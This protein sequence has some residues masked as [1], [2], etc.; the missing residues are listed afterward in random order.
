M[1][2]SAERFDLAIE[3]RKTAQ[4]QIVGFQEKIQRAETYLEKLTE[5][6]ETVAA[7]AENIPAL[8][9]KR[10]KL[11]GRALFSC[12]TIGMVS[13]RQ[14]GAVHGIEGAVD[15]K[16]RHSVQPALTSGIASETGE[17]G[18]DS[19][20]SPS[21]GTTGEKG[22]AGTAKASIIISPQNGE[23]ERRGWRRRKRRLRQAGRGWAV[24][25]Q[26]DSNLWRRLSPERPRPW[27]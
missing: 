10:V 7:I 23:L 4:E 20:E 26:S 1:E 18:S 12:A 27:R 25:D 16:G 11:K 22:D 17:G 21:E 9:S 3:A 13:E 5:P 24:K 6:K 15:K 8:S 14:P 2:A 19:K